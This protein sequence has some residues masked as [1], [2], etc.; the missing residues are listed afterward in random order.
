MIKRGTFHY[1]ICTRGGLQRSQLKRQRGRKHLSL[2]GSLRR[3][4]V[5]VTGGGAVME[6]S[7]AEI[8]T[9]PGPSQTLDVSDKLSFDIPSGNPPI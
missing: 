9:E 6:T 3:R 2:E 8:V 7:K 5:V 4:Q 1:I